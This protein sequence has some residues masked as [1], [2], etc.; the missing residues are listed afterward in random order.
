MLGT[1]VLRG[2]CATARPGPQTAVYQQPTVKQRGLSPGRRGE[3]TLGPRVTRP[4][5]TRAWSRTGA[6]GE[7]ALQ[8]PDRRNVAFSGLKSRSPRS[9]RTEGDCQLYGPDFCGSGCK[10]PLPD[11]FAKPMGRKP[12]RIKDLA[13]LFGSRPVARLLRANSPVCKADSILREAT[14]A[15]HPQRVRGRIEQPGAH[16]RPRGRRL[17]LDGGGRFPAP[18]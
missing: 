1:A 10:A 14:F 7:S 3:R 2:G 16:V 13:L 17:G 8:G 15:L 4:G 5:G 11:Q 12:W 9:R 18:T 6:T